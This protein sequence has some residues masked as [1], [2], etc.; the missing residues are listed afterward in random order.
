VTMRVPAS[1]LGARL[2]ALL[3]LL[4]FVAIVEGGSDRSAVV[5]E[6]AAHSEAAATFLSSQ[7]SSRQDLHE[8][9]KLN[10]VSLQTSSEP[11]GS[12][13]DPH[14]L[15]TVA[16]SQKKKAEEATK[17]AT[18]AQKVANKVFSRA[19]KMIATVAAARKVADAQRGAEQTK[20]AKE[21]QDANS[22]TAAAQSA[23]RA[24]KY[25]IRNAKTE[26]RE[27]KSVME[28]YLGPDRMERAERHQV[29]RREGLETVLNVERDKVALRSKQAAKQ[30]AQSKTKARSQRLAEA[31]KIGEDAANQVIQETLDK[32]KAPMAKVAADN[33]P[34]SSGD[35][36]QDAF[37]KDASFHGGLKNTQ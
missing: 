6:D 3:L 2:L 15:L 30:A 4:A 28:S 36:E 22:A 37:N 14:E 29:L 24:A 21:M 27:A 23:M 9:S 33:A 25:A 34:V 26:A 8:I 17:A 10:T 11:A 13:E 16:R 32:G 7:G 31:R 1:L 35:S 19:K 20:A 12:P 5:P 18:D